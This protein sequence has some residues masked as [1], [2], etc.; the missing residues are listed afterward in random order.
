MRHNL[1]EGHNAKREG[2]GWGEGEKEGERRM[3]LVGYGAG[4]MTTV[5]A[6]LGTLRALGSRERVFADFLSSS[7]KVT[8][9]ECRC[10]TFCI[11]TD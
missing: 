6:A 1:V 4:N 5:R 10:W 2:T 3:T 9:D 8:N 7:R 11:A